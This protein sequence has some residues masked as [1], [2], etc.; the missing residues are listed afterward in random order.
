MTAPL[1]IAPLNG[2]LGVLTPGMGAVS[3]TDYYDWDARRVI[4]EGS[5]RDAWVAAR[6]ARDD[7]ADILEPR[8]V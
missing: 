7:R 8:T 1:T 4:G 2:T 3:T 5:T 6:A